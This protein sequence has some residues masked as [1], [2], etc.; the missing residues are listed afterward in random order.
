M[1]VLVLNGPNMGTLGQREPAIYGIQTLDE[2]L[3]SLRACTESLSMEMD[4]V[5]SEFEGELLQHLHNAQDNYNF[6]II[7]PGA[8]THTSY[9]LRDA[10]AALEVPV[11]EVHVSNIAARESWRNKSVISSVCWGTISGLGAVG[12]RLAMEAGYHLFHNVLNIDQRASHTP[13][14]PMPEPTHA[15]M[16]VQRTEPMPVQRTEPMPVQ[17]TEPMPEPLPERNEPAVYPEQFSAQA[18]AFSGVTISDAVMDGEEAELP[19][20]M[21]PAADRQPYA[22]PMANPMASSLS[23]G[24]SIEPFEAEAMQGIGAVSGLFSGVPENGGEISDGEPVFKDLSS[25]GLILE[26][27]RYKASQPAAEDAQAKKKKRVNLELVFDDR[28]PSFS[29]P[30]A[31]AQEQASP[32][33][34][35]SLELVLPTAHKA[36]DQQ[37]NSKAFSIANGPLPDTEPDGGI[38]PSN[39]STADIFVHDEDI[40][41][42][43][44]D[45]AEPEPTLFS[46]S[47]SEAAQTTEAW[48]DTPLPAEEH[49]SRQQGGKGKKGWRK[50]LGRFYESGGK[51][52]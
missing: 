44:A 6:V 36:D 18:A 12:Y 41:G 8:L 2:V 17:R 48:Q 26:T 3:D 30:N 7:N 52:R 27:Q 14:P 47:Q 35:S 9:A 46:G 25:S 51:R 22:D 4:A 34:H 28:K 45:Y 20:F 50:K 24:V 23:A 43:Q 39:D 38:L 10:I 15:P 21:M 19:A 11:I 5:Q 42:S 33:K 49:S 40:L 31:A 37:D 29:E 13:A 32:K 1:R 16:P